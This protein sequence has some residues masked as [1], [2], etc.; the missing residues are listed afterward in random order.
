MNLEFKLT[1][2]R[3]HT[4]TRT[5]QWDRASFEN[6]NNNTNKNS[7]I[8]STT[9]YTIRVNDAFFVSCLSIHITIIQNKVYVTLFVKHIII[10]IHLVQNL[11]PGCVEILQHHQHHHL[12]LPPFSVSVSPPVSLSVQQAKKWKTITCVLH[13]TNGEHNGA[14]CLRF[15]LWMYA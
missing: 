12:H 3:A 9:T 8:R 5:F 4:Y 6:N 10:T 15:I 2:L 11:G 14:K 13:S 7:S 1:H